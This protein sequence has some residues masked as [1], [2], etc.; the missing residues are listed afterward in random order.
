MFQP[1]DETRVP[2]SADKFAPK[3]GYAKDRDLGGGISKI[4]RGSKK[5]MKKKKGKK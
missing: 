1:V 3:K 5:G 4:E 2:V